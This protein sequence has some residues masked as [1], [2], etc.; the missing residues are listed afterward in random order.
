MEQMYSQDMHCLVFIKM[1]KNGYRV[2]E[3]SRILE[4]SPSTISRWTRKSS[5]WDIAGQK[6]KKSINTRRR[7]RAEK[8]ETIFKYLQIFFSQKNYQFNIKNFINECLKCIG[9]CVSISTI[10]RYL[11]ILKIS[12]KR[13]SNKVLGQYK[14]HQ[15]KEYNNRRN[16]LLT[17]YHN[18]IILSIDESHFSENVVPLYGYSPLGTKCSIVNGN[19]NWTKYSLLSCISS[20]GDHVH[21]LIQG[22]VKRNDFVEFIKHL[23]FPKDSIL[24]LDNCSIH[25][26]CEN[27]FQE[28]GYQELF[29]PPYSPNLQP[30]ELAFSKIKTCYR[31]LWPWSN[32]VIGAVHESVQTLTSENIKGY[33]RQ[34]E[35]CRKEV[36]RLIFMDSI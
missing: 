35:R 29:L 33:F 10:R 16:K 12:R 1:Q 3:T 14:P 21:K 24:L 4:I 7:K 23:P 32:G 34:A 8:N 5:W 11:K 27:I 25:K 31:N 13:L 15:V 19:G 6:Q 36:T 2:R 26:N 9:Y 20:T 17:S 28:K 18:S 30:I 22:S